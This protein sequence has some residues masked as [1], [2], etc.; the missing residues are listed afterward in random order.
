MHFFLT[1]VRVFI[2]V[3][4]YMQFAYYSMYTVY[5][6]YLW[7]ITVSFPQLVSSLVSCVCKQKVCNNVKWSVRWIKPSLFISNT[8]LSSKAICFCSKCWPHILVLTFF[9]VDSTIKACERDPI[10][11]MK[12]RISPLLPLSGILRSF[13]SF[14]AE[15]WLRQEA[16]SA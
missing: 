12:P 1:E 4:V 13:E 2:C 14:A 15:F 10:D 11:G 16:L 8:P 9:K 7:I 5:S 6:K 3:C